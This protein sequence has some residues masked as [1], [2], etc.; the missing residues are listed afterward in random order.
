MEVSLPPRPPYPDESV[1]QLANFPVVAVRRP[2]CPSHGG[3]GSWDLKPGSQGFSTSSRSLY[4]H[5]RLF[6]QTNSNQLIS[7]TSEPLQLS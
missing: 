6:V 3:Q 2:N 5:R 7:I 4:I 1:E